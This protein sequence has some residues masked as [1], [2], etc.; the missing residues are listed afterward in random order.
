[1]KNLY[2]LTLLTVLSAIL[3]MPSCLAQVNQGDS[4]YMHASNFTGRGRNGFGPGASGPGRT[5][6]GMAGTSRQQ[7]SNNPR[8]VD[9][10]RQILRPGNYQQGGMMPTATPSLGHRSFDMSPIP[11]GNF[12]YGFDT[13][14]QQSLNGVKISSRFGGLPATSTASVDFDI[15]DVPTRSNGGIPATDPVGAASYVGDPS[16]LLGGSCANPADCYGPLG[17]VDCYGGSCSGLSLGSC[18]GYDM[19]GCGGYS[20][21]SCGGYDMSGCGGY[22]SGSCGGYDM[23]GCGGYSSGSCGGYDMSGCGGYSSGSCGGYDMSGCGG[24][25]SGCSY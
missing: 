13:N 18:S 21:G 9:Y 20:S 4:G 2:L 5:V 10:G 16:G 14:P 25:S 11:S 24:Y 22:S 12:H 19:S 17:V 7:V 8:S 23:S 15:C 6:Y 1:M 3:F